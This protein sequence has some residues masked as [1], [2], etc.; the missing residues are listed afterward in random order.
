[1]ILAAMLV[2]CAWGIAEAKEALVPDEHQQIVTVSRLRRADEASLH[3]RRRRS[4]ADVSRDSEDE[5][6]EFR[7]PVYNITAF[8]RQMIIVLERDEKLVSPALTV[9]YT[10]SAPN[11]SCNITNPK[12]FPVKNCFYKGYVLDEEES[13]SVAMSICDSLIG[14]ISTARFHYFIE[15]L[16][17]QRP[18][19]DGG[20]EHLIKRRDPADE[21]Q[22]PPTDK[23]G[24]SHHSSYTKR[25]VDEKVT[26][27]P[28]P[29]DPPSKFARSNRLRLSQLEEA[30][31]RRE[32]RDFNANEYFI[33]A[34]VVAD[35]SLYDKYEN[36]LEHYIL[37]IMSGANRIFSHPS[38]GMVIS[39]IVTKVRQSSPMCGR[40]LRM[41]RDDL[42]CRD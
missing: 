2:V 30:S 38:L 7:H 13:S 9:S 42:F 34:M 15:P 33:E 21:R 8:G 25:Q 20:V 23:C 39:I 11:V 40:L 4:I 27:S 12:R 32:K 26:T 31:L 36:D 1:M 35:K 22:N 3:F 10:S 28:P 19:A 5:D 37:T 16:K 14:S 6:E 24:N 18:G 29:T 41:P 17:Q